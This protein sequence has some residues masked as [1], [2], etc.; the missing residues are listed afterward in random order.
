[1]DPEGEFRSALIDSARSWLADAAKNGNV[2]A[3]EKILMAYDPDFQFLRPVSANTEVNIENFV[4]LMPGIPTEML[5][6][7]KQ[8]LLESK[9]KELPVIDA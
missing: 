5:Q 7:L 4:Q 9:Q 2:R 6:Q 8:A 3:I 1:M